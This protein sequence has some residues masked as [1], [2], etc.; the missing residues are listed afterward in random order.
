MESVS[1]FPFRKLRFEIY[2]T[3]EV[4]MHIDHQDAYKFMFN[5]NN[6]DIMRVNI[7]EVLNKI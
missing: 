1:A 4:M 3:L 7:H 2:L 6:F 5:I